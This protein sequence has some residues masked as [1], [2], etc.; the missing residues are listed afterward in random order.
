MSKALSSVA[1]LIAIISGLIAAPGAQTP[2][3]ALSS[4]WYDDDEWHLSVGYII[5]ADESAEYRELK[6]LEARDDF[7]SRF[8]KRRDPTP[9]TAD[10][11]FRTEFERRV[12]YADAHFTE[13]NSPGQRGMQ[14]DRGR[15][16]VL[17]GAPDSIQPWPTGAFEVWRYA[18]TVGGAS[19]FTVQFSL[20]PVDSCDGS[21]RVRAPEPTTTFTGT[22]TTIEVYPARF[23]TARIAVDFTTTAIVTHKLRTANGQPVLENDAAFWDGQIGPAGA[24]PLSKHLLGCRMFD[25]G[26]M[27]F[28]HPL[29]PG[30]Y[31]FSSSLTSVTGTVQTDAVTFEVK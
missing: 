6:T 24:D 10:N 11:E 29:P 4:D 5:T 9:D 25:P 31:I 1:A 2:S 15:I 21:Y 19:N 20:P 26:G 22:R 3:H 14:T 17:F 16:Y 12:E 28:T 13:P 7:I 8:W 23:V 30:R 27:G 18:A